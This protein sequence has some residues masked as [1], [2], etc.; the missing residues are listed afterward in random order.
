MTQVWPIFLGLLIILGIIT[1]FKDKNHFYF[2]K[3]LILFAGLLIM[4]TIN[5]LIFFVLAFLFI[6]TD[7]SLQLGNLFILLG[8][9]VVISGILLYWG[10]KAFNH[11]FPL[12]TT[13][14][15]LIEY[16]IQWTLIYVTVYQAIF[17]NIKKITKV[18]HYITVG[19]F[20]DPNLFVV[21]VLP[22]FISAWIGLILLKKHIHAI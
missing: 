8:I 9:L 21:I 19:N 11:F 4:S 16:Y 6:H 22:S 7:K 10:L 1:L 15:T 3:A 18:A 17:S 12:S 2:I 14:L 5:F 20:L 13:T